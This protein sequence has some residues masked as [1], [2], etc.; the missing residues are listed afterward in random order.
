MNAHPTRRDS[1]TLGGVL[2]ALVVGCLILAS[3][4]EPV[5]EKAQVAL[6]SAESDYL[7]DHQQKKRLA[8]LKAAC[9]NSDAT[10]LDDGPVCLPR[11]KAARP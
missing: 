7:Y 8:D 11:R 5:V 1:I 10:W 6:N 2:G 4:A 9:P 3:T